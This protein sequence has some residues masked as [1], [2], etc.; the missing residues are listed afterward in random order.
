MPEERWCELVSLSSKNER[1]IT[2]EHYHDSPDL[3]FMGIQKAIFRLLEIAPVNMRWLRVLYELLDH[4][5]PEQVAT[6]EKIDH[7]LDRWATLD[8][9]TPKGK[10]IEGHHTS[11]SIK[12]EFRCLIAALYG[13]GFVNNVSVLHGSPGA[14]DIALR[15]AYYGKGN[16]TPNEMK[17][18]YKRDEEAFI[19][20]V[21]FNDS[22]YANPALRKP[23]QEEFWGGMFSRYS[24]YK[25]EREQRKKQR[26][27]ALWGAE[28]DLANESD[29]A[30]LASHQSGAQKAFGAVGYAWQVITNLFYL[31]VIAFVLNRTSQLDPKLTIIVATLG[32]IYVTIRGLAMSQTLA[33]TPALLGIARGIDE[34]KAL[35]GG[36]RDATS[37]D[38][39][40]AI[41]QLKR[42]RTKVYIQSLFLSLT[43]IICL[44]AI[45]TALS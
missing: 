9:R 30:E 8:D 21:L 35:G 40:A 36:K 45:Y 37:Q 19:F 39:V 34:L 28:D 4:L 3:A 10:A 27:E 44:F 41:A 14:K 11:L 6:A 43:S 1:L 23:L 15:R 25:R 38:Y 33:F 12:D 32:L 18:G 7:V 5:A 22:I 24:K 17:A 42:S 16:I 20:A 31:A 2:K 26:H 13:R 29:D